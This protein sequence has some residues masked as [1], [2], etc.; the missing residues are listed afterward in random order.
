MKSTS[1]TVGSFNQPN[2]ARSL[3]ELPGNAEKGLNQRFLWYF[4][5]PVYGHFDSLEP[6]D[7]NFRSKIG[8][9]HVD[10]CIASNAAY[11]IT[12]YGLGTVE[13]LAILWKKPATL[14][15]AGRRVFSLPPQGL[16]T[17]VFKAK[18]DRMQKQLTVH[19]CCR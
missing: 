12:C 9:Q 19:C 11:N 17:S 13:N 10:A 4:P 7:K 3:I 2:V 6:T 15:T 5:K 8:K 1:L 14:K 16:D 18:Y